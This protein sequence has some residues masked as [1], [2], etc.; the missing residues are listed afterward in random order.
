[1][2]TEVQRKNINA[3]HMAVNPPEVIVNADMRVINSTDGYIYQYVRIGW[4]QER[5][6]ERK[7]YENIPQLID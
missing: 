4:V 3:I 7:D 6:A 5:K 2:S 1:M